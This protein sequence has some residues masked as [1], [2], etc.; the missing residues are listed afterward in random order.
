MYK[1]YIDDLRTCPNGYDK[2][3]RST[4]ETLNCIQKRYKAGGRTFLLDLDHDAGD[5][6]PG[7]DFINVLKSLEDLQRSGYYK[8]CKFHVKIHSMNPVGRMNMEAM[9]KEPWFYKE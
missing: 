3:C 1:I 5:N 6:A 4:N 9:I 7:G 2:C 8:N